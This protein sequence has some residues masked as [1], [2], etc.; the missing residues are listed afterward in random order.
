MS[1]LDIALPI[2]ERGL[3]VCP[4]V[5][6]EKFPVKMSWGDHF[7]AA[8]TERADLEQWDKEVPNANVGIIPDENFCFVETDDEASL[9]EACE[10]LPPE[11]WNTTRVSARENRCYYIFR[12]TMRTRRAGNMTKERVQLDAEG[13]RVLDEKDKPT[14]GVQKRIH[15]SR[16]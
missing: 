9:K 11:I 7:D 1:F 4:L 15:Q 5:P 16:S 8:T 12:Q 2:T 14:C 6:K 10:D 3:R 13:N